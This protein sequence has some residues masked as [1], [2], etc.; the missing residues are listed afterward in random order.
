MSLA[1]PT[2]SVV[3]PALNEAANLRASYERLRDTLDGLVPGWMLILVDDGSTD[4]TFALMQA[5][6]SEDA[7][8]R[9]LRLSRNFG[10]HV[11]ITAGLEMATGDAAL[12]ITAD[13]EEPAEAI[14]QFLAQWRAGEEVI[15]GVREQRSDSLLNQATSAA[16]HWLFRQFGLS[17]YA[18]EGVG[19]GF[20]LV[21]RRVLQALRAM[22]EG[23]RTIIGL[24]TWVGFRQG[25]VHYT[26]QKQAGRVSRWTL[27]KKIKL[28]IDS[29][30]GFSDRPIR[31]ISLTGIVIA[32]ASF[33]YATVL[34]LRSVML[35]V[36]V[37]G[38]PTLMVV[39]LFLGG[40]QLVV[41]GVMGE[42]LWR[43]VDDARRRPLYI[44]ADHCN[45]SEEQR[46]LPRSGVL[47][48]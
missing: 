2:L 38:W 27:G 17:D 44:I 11:A 15:W 23:N 21:D 10:S 9:A 36:A 31:L 37:Q 26:Q 18:R 4:G 47:T 43:G 28:A 16:F 33:L 45:L 12:V 48:E 8:V 19:G 22:P 30:V 40:M 35:G 3:V 6:A 46:R 39:V 41:T 5:L 32:A 20:F 34:V 14:G 24:L 13:M 25:F 1:H 29:F 7:R 42:Y